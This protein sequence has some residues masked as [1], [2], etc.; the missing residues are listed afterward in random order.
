MSIEKEF[1]IVRLSRVVYAGLLILYPRDL[2]H[3][4]G[5][6][7]ADVFEEA[8]HDAIVERGPAGVT[9]LWRSA[10]LELLTVALPLRLASNAVM[11]G[12]ISFLA[13]SVLVLVFFRAVS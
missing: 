1:A 10:L 6:E 12:A 7:M 3:K 4:F 8:V 9:S 2:R 13:S 11:A 5:A